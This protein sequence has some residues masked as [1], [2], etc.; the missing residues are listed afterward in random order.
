MRVGHETGGTIRI[1]ARLRFRV[2]VWV[3]VVVMF[4]GKSFGLGSGGGEYEG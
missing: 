3:R 4:T 2:R 1:N